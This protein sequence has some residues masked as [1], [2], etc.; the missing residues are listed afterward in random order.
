M[1]SHQT[2]LGSILTSMLES[3][4]QLHTAVAVRPNKASGGGLV[5]AWAR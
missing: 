2:A 5:T 1:L 4:H 3:E